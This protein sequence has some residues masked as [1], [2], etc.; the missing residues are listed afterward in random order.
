MSTVVHGDSGPYNFLVDSDR[1]TAVL[2]WEFAHVGDPAEDLGIA[3]VYA[4][5]VMDWREFLDIYASAGGPEVPEHRVRLAM[6]LQFLKGTTLVAASGRNFEEGWT[7]EFIKGANAFTG[8]RLIEL[9]IAALLRRF[10]AL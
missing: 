1:L 10:Q 3:R 5:D 9:K 2:D 7:R 6:V 4:E 8:L